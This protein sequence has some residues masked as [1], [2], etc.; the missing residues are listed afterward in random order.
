MT[1]PSGIGYDGRVVPMD[2]AYPLAVLQV[3]GTP[4]SRQ[5]I[6]F[7]GYCSYVD[8]EGNCQIGQR[9]G[10]LWVKDG[11]HVPGIR[12]VKDLVEARTR[13]FLGKLK[14][15]R[16]VAELSEEDLNSHEATQLRKQ[17]ER[18]E[19]RVNAGRPHCVREDKFSA[20]CGR[21]LD[22]GECGAHDRVLVAGS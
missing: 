6:S 5:S 7:R 11:W 15:K 4:Q 14:Q 19:S 8:Y 1:P 22:I 17:C 10:D 21:R 2:R 20:A 16:G 12:Y 18:I 13:G 3:T 9:R